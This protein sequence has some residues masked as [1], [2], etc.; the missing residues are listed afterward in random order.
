MG[1]VRYKSTAAVADAT[2]KPSRNSTPIALT[3]DPDVASD[4]VGRAKGE[5]LPAAQGVGHDAAHVGGC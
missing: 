5:S 4:W 3:V 1:S 2:I